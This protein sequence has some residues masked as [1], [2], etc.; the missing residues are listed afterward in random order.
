MARGRHT[1]WIAWSEQN[2]PSQMGEKPFGNHPYEETA[3]YHALL[4]FLEALTES[5]HERGAGIRMLLSRRADQSQV[6]PFALGIDLEN[7]VKKSWV[8]FDEPVIEYPNVYRSYLLQQ[9]A[10]TADAFFAVGGGKAM[11]LAWVTAYERGALLPLPFF[12]GVSQKV[13]KE[14]SFS[15]E[16]KREL[17]GLQ[18]KDDDSELN[19]PPHW[20]V[21]QLL[22]HAG[23]VRPDFTPP[24]A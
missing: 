21:E 6:R 3:D 11:D 2:A 17:S 23:G 15:T 20:T 16:L 9:Q 1:L 7:F 12:G 10:R 8:T 4:G 18:P 22:H 24:V 13:F 14:R 5:L 19:F